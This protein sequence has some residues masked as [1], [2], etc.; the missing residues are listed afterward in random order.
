MGFEKVAYR[1]VVGAADCRGQP[2]F[3]LQAV[4]PA[5][6]HAKRLDY[7]IRRREKAR[8]RAINVFK[9]LSIMGNQMGC[10]SDQV[11]EVSHEMQT[12]IM[13]TML[14]QASDLDL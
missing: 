10:N 12:M 7:F 5:S 6:C 14:S 8:L 1:I 3:R 9:G 2:R 4:A 11:G 13:N